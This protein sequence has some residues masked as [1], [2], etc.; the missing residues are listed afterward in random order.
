MGRPVAQF[1]G[2]WPFHR[3]LGMQEPFSVLFSLLNLAAHLHGLARLR[4]RVPPSYPLLRYY[5]LFSYVASASWV[6]S[7][8]FH[9]RDFPLTEELD[10]LG[11]GASVF[12][13]MFYA[14]VRVFRLDRPDSASRSKLKA[15]TAIC[16]TLYL[17][18]VGYLK[19]V[20][21]DYTYNMAANVVAG[22]AHN[23]LWFWYCARRYGRTGQAWT[24]WP[25]V[26][27]TWIMA[28]MSLELFDF[29]PIWGCFDAHSLW[30][31]GTIVPAYLWYR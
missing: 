20:T 30:H 11:A 29:P 16:A 17:A 24:L 18:H 4:S 28:A 19:G 5:K 31:L 7:A 14:P 21:W 13:S 9:A 1:H 2:K 23:A 26:C 10:Y 3:L 6:F 15:W 22:L 25:V 8:V 12:Y 27:A